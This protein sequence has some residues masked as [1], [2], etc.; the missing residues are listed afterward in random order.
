MNR[1]ERRNE[2]KPLS[3]RSPFVPDPVDRMKD[4]SKVVGRGI[5][6]RAGSIVCLFVR[7][8]DRDLNHE[9][10]RGDETLSVLRQ[11]GA[12]RCD[13]RRH[14]EPR[15]LFD[16][17]HGPPIEHGFAAPEIDRRGV[18]V[19]LQVPQKLDIALRR[20]FV[21]P[22]AADGTGLQKTLIAPLPARVAS[23][24]AQIR[25]AYA[26]LPYAFARPFTLTRRQVLEEPIDLY[27]GDVPSVLP[28]LKDLRRSLEYGGYW[29]PALTHWMFLLH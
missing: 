8:V 3:S 15:G 7:P 20:D 5:R 22:E 11:P 26:Q 25:D 1:G 13:A 24:V 17:V 2:R 9:H 12:V 27:H 21:L 29:Y 6:S 18:A 28:L 16:H 10:R 23:K 4:G 19:L 14:V